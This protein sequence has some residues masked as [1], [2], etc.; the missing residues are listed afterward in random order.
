M[1]QINQIES[2]RTGTELTE[3]VDR[4]RAS[5]TTAIEQNRIRN[6]TALLVNG[7]KWRKY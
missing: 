1:T 2:E 5:L 4:D 6:N 7:E 3:S